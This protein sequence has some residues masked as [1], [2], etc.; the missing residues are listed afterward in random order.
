LVGK[1]LPT[2]HTNKGSFSES[3]VKYFCQSASCGNI[4][5]VC[6]GSCSAMQKRNYGQKCFVR[7]SMTGQ[8]LKTFHAH[9]LM[10][11]IGPALNTPTNQADDLMEEETFD[12]LDDTIDIDDIHSLFNVL[13]CND[14]VEQTFENYHLHEYLHLV[15]SNRYY[16]AVSHLVRQAAFS[17]KDTGKQM[18]DS[19]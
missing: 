4:W 14:V 10:D 18:A 7:K 3:V 15:K 5:F 2:V 6:D 19:G 11:T 13:S 17:C 16:L 9:A 12:H 1:T 8:H